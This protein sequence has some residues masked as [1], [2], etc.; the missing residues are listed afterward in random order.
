MAAAPWLANVVYL[1][2]ANPLPGFDWTPLAF[3]VSGILLAYAIFRIGLLDLRPIARAV[4]FEQM[5]DAL[6]GHFR[7]LVSHVHERQ[8]IAHQARRGGQGLDA[9]Q[10][11]EVGLIHAFGLL[12]ARRPVGDEHGLALRRFYRTPQDWVVR[13]LQGPLELAL[14]ELGPAVRAWEFRSD[15][16]RLLIERLIEERDLAATRATA[17]D[18]APDDIVDGRLDAERVVAVRVPGL[19]H[20]AQLV[21]QLAQANEMLHALLNRFD[22]PIQHGG[23][24]AQTHPR[25]RAGDLAP[26]VPTDFARE[27]LLVDAL[28]IYLQTASGQ[29]VQPRR[30]QRAQGVLIAHPRYLRNLHNLDCGKSLDMHLRTH[31]LHRM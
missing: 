13:H 21:L 3:T 6:L 30:F 29:A 24:L 9:R 8:F 7:P 5:G 11:L 23:I 25:R 18:L 17:E 31:F 4:L 28:G 16:A 20:P 2:G 15:P 19:V 12:P 1:S 22:V 10:E 14:V 27:Q 26:L